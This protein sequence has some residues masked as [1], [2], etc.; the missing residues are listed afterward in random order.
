[1]KYKGVHTNQRDFGEC[2][3]LKDFAMRDIF[4]YKYIYFETICTTYD[5]L[6][7]QNLRIGMEAHS[8]YL[9]LLKTTFADRNIPPWYLTPLK[10][11]GYS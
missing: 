8:A 5:N 10:N 1:M 7:R 3:H 9:V 11:G 6:T 2:I 4:W